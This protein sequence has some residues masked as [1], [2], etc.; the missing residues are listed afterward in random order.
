MWFRPVSCT[1]NLHCT[2]PSTRLSVSGLEVSACYALAQGAHP[3]MVLRS[4]VPT[5]WLWGTEM[6][7]A[8]EV[9][10]LKKACEF[11]LSLPADLDESTPRGVS[12]CVCMYCRNLSVLQPSVL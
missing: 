2:G 8:G 6:P 5:A 4:A 3:R 12:Q 9:G 7:A 10:L 11:P 1:Y